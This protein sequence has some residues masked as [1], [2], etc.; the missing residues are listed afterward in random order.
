MPPVVV[1]T[2]GYRL[3]P[4]EGFE[5]ASP[6]AIGHDTPEATFE[7]NDGMLNVAMKTHCATVPEARALIE[8]ILRA[9]EIHA[10]IPQSK[11]VF[12]FVYQGATHVD[13]DPDTGFSTGRSV[14]TSSH[15]LLY[16]LVKST[17]TSKTYP[18]IPTDFVQSDLLEALWLRFCQVGE[19]REL[20]LSMAY[21][22]LTK[23]EREWG[24]RTNAAAALNVD[25]PVLKK[26]GDLVSDHGDDLTARKAKVGLPLTDPQQT[27][28]QECLKMLIR[29]VGH[30]AALA[31]PM[32]SMADLPPL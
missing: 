25:F 28:V 12:R 18:P 32:L 11:P 3:A 8:P 27:W 4:C 17:I 16:D 15:I 14:V 30:P 2:L 9:W 7:L 10:G 23:L 20:L 6:P 1:E 24:N 19:Q 26:L 13:L 31:A 22:A 21:W 5:F 29:R